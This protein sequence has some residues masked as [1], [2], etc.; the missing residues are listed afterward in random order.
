MNKPKLYFVALV[1]GGNV[2]D[3]VLALKHEVH[4]RY[5][6]KAAL[7]SPPH[8]TLHMPIQWQEENENKLVISLDDLAGEYKPFPIDLDGFGAFPPRVIY[9][10]VSENQ[11][12]SKLQAAVQKLARAIWHIYPKS[13]NTRPF[14][15]HMTFAFR[16]LKKPM[17]FKA[18]QEFE[19]REYTGQFMAKDICLLKH[20]G[21]HW[22][23]LHRSPL[24]STY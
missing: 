1:P 6:S 2:F 9:V 3:E 14:T 24:R 10:S 17:F 8:I 12:L 5:Q 22:E 4:E 19:Q 13:T 16:D 18:W 11:E 21:K 23:I 20:N 7:R 15:P